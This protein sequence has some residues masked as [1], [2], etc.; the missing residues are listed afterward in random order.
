VIV[1]SLVTIDFGFLI[2]TAAGVPQRVSVLN[3]QSSITNQQP[4]EDQQSTISQ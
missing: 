4:I 1:E 3:Q 2:E